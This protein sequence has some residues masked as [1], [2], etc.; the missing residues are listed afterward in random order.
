LIL[1]LS[2]SPE[3]EACLQLKILS[4]KKAIPTDLLDEE[5]ALAKRSTKFGQRNRLEEFKKTVVLDSL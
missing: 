4:A 5:I 3:A 2:P 1:S